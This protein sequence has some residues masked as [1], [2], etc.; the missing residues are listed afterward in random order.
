[1]SR[2]TE[3]TSYA[4]YAPFLKARFGVL[5]ESKRNFSHAYCAK[6]LGSTSSYLKHALEG[7]RKIGLSRVSKIAELFN[8][9]DFETQYFTVMVIRELTKDA[10][11]RNYLAQVLQRLKFEKHSMGEV[12]S[13]QQASEATTVP[14]ANWLYGT[15]LE[16]MSFSDFKD[17]D[18]WIL[19]KL[20]D[21]S[22]LTNR[23]VR[24]A[25]DDMIA[26][27][28][29]QKKGSSLEIIQETLSVPNPFDANGFKVYRGIVRK[30]WEVLASPADY[31]KNH[32]LE[33][34]MAVSADDEL[35]IFRAA[36]EFRDRVLKIAQ[37]TKNPSRVLVLSNN[38]FNLVR[39][40]AP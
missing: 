12:F 10:K 31:A 24:A 38:L 35:A 14:L 23:E 13:V 33:L 19:S 32:F 40:A 30:T 39:S 7:R 3:I 28:I 17:D 34:I 11:T 21:G 18:D 16:L 37:K 25:I 2:K 27:K 29:I 5:K 36:E 8:L 20:V 15:L 22:S 1:M 6:K 9:D 4:H 26:K